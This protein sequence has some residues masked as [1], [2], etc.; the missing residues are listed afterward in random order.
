MSFCPILTSH[1]M[2]FFIIVAYPSVASVIVAFYPIFAII[3]FFLLVNLGTEKTKLILPKKLKALRAK[4]NF[5]LT[6]HSFFG[7][8]NIA[9]ILAILIKTVT[10]FLW[11][12]FFV[13]PI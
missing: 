11:L 10:S 6:K 1:S 12:L 4:M 13:V 5:F 9:N 7:N 2:W 8:K 3:A